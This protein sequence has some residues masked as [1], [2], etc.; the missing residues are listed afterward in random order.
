M[1]W[2]DGGWADGGRAEVAQADGGHHGY[3]PLSYDITDTII[4]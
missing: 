1:G 3:L 2:A 4:C